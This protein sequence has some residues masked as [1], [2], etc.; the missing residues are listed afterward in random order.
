MPLRTPSPPAPAERDTS[1][2][3]LFEAAVGSI[4][5]DPNTLTRLRATM[6]TAQR[7]MFDDLAFP[8]EE[9]TV[10]PDLLDHF[11]R[12][13]SPV[14]SPSYSSPDRNNN[15]RSQ[16][17]NT[18]TTCGHCRNL[19]MTDWQTH[20]RFRCR[21]LQDL[22]PCRTCG[23]SNENNHTASHCPRQLPTE[24]V[25]RE[26][27]ANVVVQ[28]EREIRDEI[29]ENNQQMYENTPNSGS[30]ANSRKDNK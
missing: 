24:L 3:L 23:A 10:S 27:S 14:R 13:V 20:S 8:V 16:R 30:F 6:T 15:R 9:Q 1:E 17:V 4:H 11:L 29:S 2:Q 5:H 28:R 12:P 25:L 19:G 22:A 21:R 18:E 26:T 7:Q